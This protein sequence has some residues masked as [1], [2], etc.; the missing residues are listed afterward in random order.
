MTGHIAIVG[1]GLVGSG[2]TIVFARAGETVRVFD[3]IPAVRAEFPLMVER[4]LNDLKRF[5]L[6]DD[7]EAIMARI[8]V[9]DSL[10]NA[11]SGARYIQESVFE[12][13]DTKTAISAEIG[14]LL[15]DGAVVGSSTSG[16]PGS[17]FTENRTASDSSFPIRSTRHTWCRSSRLFRR[18]GPHPMPLKRRWRS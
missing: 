15:D 9:C 4:Q 5:D 18:P 6:V 7:V 8:T 11:V 1:A 16:I 17:A 3:G 12:Q 13:I 14:P 10:S 2:W